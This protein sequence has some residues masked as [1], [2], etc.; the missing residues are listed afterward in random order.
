MLKELYDRHGWSLKKSISTEL[1]EENNNQTA[2]IVCYPKGN[3]R[4][5]PE[6]AVV[7]AVA[8]KSTKME[9]EQEASKL[10]LKKLDRMYR[11]QEIPLSA[12]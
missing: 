3:K 2:T 1:D 6:N 10:S 11:I 8:T 5:N 7:L 12:N 4:Q 9:A